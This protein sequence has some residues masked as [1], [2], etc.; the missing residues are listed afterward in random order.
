MSGDGV[1]KDAANLPKK[2]Q[3]KVIED[4]NKQQGQKD[5]QEHQESFDGMSQE[6]K[7]NYTAAQNEDKSNKN[8]R[9]ANTLIY[10]FNNS[11]ARSAAGSDVNSNASRAAGEKAGKVAVGDSHKERNK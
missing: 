1:T 9:A 11:S 10:E 3:Q 5:L 7:D 8:T 6:Q 2:V 4:V